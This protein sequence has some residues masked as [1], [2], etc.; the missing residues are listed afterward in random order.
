MQKSYFVIA[1]FIFLISASSFAQTSEKARIIKQFTDRFGKPVGQQ[2]NLFEVNT[3]FVLEVAFVDDELIK[4]S[5]STKYY[6]QKEYPEWKEPNEKPQLGAN[7]YL[8]LLTKLESVKPKGK[9]VSKGFVGECTNSNCWHQDFY[10]DAFLEYAMRGQ[11]GIGLF[12][13]SYFSIVKGRV[14]SKRIRRLEKNA[15]AAGNELVHTVTISNDDGDRSQSYYVRRDV[16][17][18]LKTGKTQTFKGA[19]VN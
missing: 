6:F 16:Y 9:I 7:D 2:S 8:I 11:D 18:K 3:D 19:F 15:L 10:Q 13:I 17:T 12:F 1:L 4:F 5:V 14:L